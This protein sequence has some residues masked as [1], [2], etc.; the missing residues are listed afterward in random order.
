M[1]AD[2]HRRLRW[3]ASALWKEAGGA[4][5]VFSY[6]SMVSPIILNSAAIHGET[7]QGRF[8]SEMRRVSVPGIVLS[9]D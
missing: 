9:L 7:G 3:G 4:A 1:Q 6:M 5:V 8:V 2:G